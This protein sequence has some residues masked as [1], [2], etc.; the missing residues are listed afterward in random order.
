MIDRHWLKTEAAHQALPE[1]DTALNHRE[2]WV[3]HSA[4]K[5]LEQLNSVVP[6]TADSRPTTVPGRATA[7]QC[8]TRRFHH[9]GRPAQDRDRDLRLAAAVAF[10]QLRERNAKSILADAARDGDPM[11]NRRPG[12]ALAA[13]N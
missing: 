6:E 13:L 9:S 5:L 8:Q 12:I 11:C 10:G 7:G 3:R 1:I 2:Y 4:T